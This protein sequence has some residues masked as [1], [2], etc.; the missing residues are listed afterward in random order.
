[1]N[2]RTRG[3][4]VP[5]DRDAKSD[6]RRSKT[7]SIPDRSEQKRVASDNEDLGAFQKLEVPFD[8]V[9]LP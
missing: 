6:A 8:P 1:M 5:K 4:N 2:T 3:K 7:A 9:L